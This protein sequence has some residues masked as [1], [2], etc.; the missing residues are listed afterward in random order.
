MNDSSSPDKSLAA[1]CG[2]YCPACPIYQFTRQNNVKALTLIAQR[3]NITLDKVY[4]TGCR[5]SVKT[6]YCTNCVMIRCASGKGIDF[7]SD[8][9]EYPCEHLLEFKKG[10]PH[11][12]EILDSLD[13]ICDAGWES[14]YVE[15]QEHYACPGCHQPN[16]WYD[17]Q[18]K[19]CGHE[20]GNAFA[21]KHHEVL[22]TRKV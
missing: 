11:R 20:P 22:S 8:C 19:S 6:D 17:F 13:R 18:C 10:M 7:C 1:V 5:T 15:M 9:H 3:M 16:G 21:G 12:V 4:C 2:L 14:W